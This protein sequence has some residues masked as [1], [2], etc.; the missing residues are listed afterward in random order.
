MTDE[1]AIEAIEQALLN[2]LQMF[3]LDIFITPE[4][5]KR[6]FTHLQQIRIRRSEAGG[7]VEPLLQHWSAHLEEFRTNILDFAEPIQ[8]ADG[9]PFRIVSE[10]VTDRA[11]ALCPDPPP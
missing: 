6:L 7:D 9:R 4:S 11:L 1:E 5:L 3:P 10:S 8:L 2:Y